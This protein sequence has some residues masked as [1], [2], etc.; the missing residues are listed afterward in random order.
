MFAAHVAAAMLFCSFSDKL[1]MYQL[2][3]FS[4]LL[5]Y[6]MPLTMHIQDPATE[7][8]K[9]ILYSAPTT[10]NETIHI[11]CCLIGILCYLVMANWRQKTAMQKFSFALLIVIL[12][13][14]P[15]TLL[16]YAPKS[17]ASYFATWQILI[18]TTLCMYFVE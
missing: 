6:I 13:L 2:L 3:V 1:K 17:V 4:E 16:V 7:M 12:L 5:V 9:K 8:W 18:G 15:C 11:V 10:R 14:V